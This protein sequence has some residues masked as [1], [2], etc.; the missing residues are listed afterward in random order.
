M[1]SKQSLKKSGIPSFV[2]Y[3]PK[4]AEVIGDKNALLLVQL[5]FWIGRVKH[6][7]EGRRWIYQTA[8]KISEEWFP[9]W[10]V[11]TV[12]RTLK[13]MQ[14]QGFL[15]VGNFNKHRYDRTRWFAIT[16]KG[17]EQ[18]QACGVPVDGLTMSSTQ[19]GKKDV[20]RLTTPGGQIGHMELVE[21]GTPIPVDITRDISSEENPKATAAAGGRGF[22]SFDDEE[23]ISHDTDHSPS[24]A[25][26]ELSSQSSD[27]HSQGSLPATETQTRPSLSQAQTLE[28]AIHSSLGLHP[29]IKI[30]ATLLDAAQTSDQSL[31]AIKRLS[32]DTTARPDVR[33]K[34]ALLTK[35]LLDGDY[36]YHPE[37]LSVLRRHGIEGQ[38]AHTVLASIRPG[39]CVFEKT[40]EQIYAIAEMDLGKQLDYRY[41][42]LDW[43]IRSTLNDPDSTGECS[44]ETDEEAQN[45]NLPGSLLELFNDA[46]S[47]WRDER[48]EEY[49]LDAGTAEEV[50]S[51]PPMHHTSA[52]AAI[53]AQAEEQ[54]SGGPVEPTSGE[55]PDAVSIVPDRTVLP[56]PE[57]VPAESA[58]KAVTQQQPGAGP[59]S[60]GTR[61]AETSVVG[62]RAEDPLY[63]RAM[64]NLELVKRQI[65][66]KGRR[67]SSMGIGMPEVP[68]VSGLVAAA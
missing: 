13:E 8:E 1:K 14:A 28:Q 41:E 25:S 2:K 37:D 67:D 7:H 26:A 51:L 47:R 57:S 17:I 45:A 64:E 9:A 24:T 20:P 34:Q 33:N 11:K 3:F 60:V 61:T 65:K 16:D 18:L 32:C 39:L 30:T 53:P 50:P 12:R 44:I 58:K 54:V 49:S 23:P 66:E 38:T 42:Q 10:G 40:L 55:G 63:L 19:I 48:V 46:V 68:E 43:I 56:L 22:S 52:S 31:S 36:I 29:N 21:V 15:M 6:E 59:A 62:Q 35:R 5:A 27:T 4:L